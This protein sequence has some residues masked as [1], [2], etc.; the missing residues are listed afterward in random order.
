MLQLDFPLV[1]ECKK[2]GFD[3]AIETN[4]TIPIDFDIDWVC[5]SPKHGSELIVKHGNELKAVFPQEGQNLNNFLDLNFLH[6]M[7]R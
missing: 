5:V 6:N 3:T 1:Q 4:G 2:N 7:M